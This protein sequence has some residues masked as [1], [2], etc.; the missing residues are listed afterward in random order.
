MKII[1]SDLSNH[2]IKTAEK[3]LGNLYFFNHVAVIEFNEGTH[4]D[5]NNSS[6][7][8]EELKSYFGVSRHF[9]VVANRINSYSVNLLDT[10]LFREQAKNLC[11][12]AVVGHNA[13]SKMNAQ[14]EN[15]FCLSENINYDNVYEAIDNVYSKVKNKILFSLN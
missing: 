3:E 1:E 13:A 10:P 12:Y 6:E 7:I 15:G 4:V 11:A 8:F 2:I 14:I 9:G 5:I